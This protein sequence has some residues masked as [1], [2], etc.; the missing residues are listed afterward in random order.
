MSFGQ[1]KHSK[2]VLLSRH[3]LGGAARARARASRA[4]LS[5]AISR[6]TF[7]MPLLTFFRRPA[8][9]VS[10]V[11]KLRHACNARLHS[12]GVPVSVESIESETC[13][14]Y[15]GP[16]PTPSRTYISASL[17]SEVASSSL[18]WIVVVLFGSYMFALLLVTHDCRSGGYPLAAARDFRSGPYL[19][20]F[21]FSCDVIHLCGFSR[22][23]GRHHR[24]WPSLILHVPLF[25]QRDFHLS[26]LRHT[27]LSL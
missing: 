19:N 12:E 25:Y 24:S 6:S 8:A 10:E 26:C 14:Y 23:L 22:A 1:S 4:S 7:C 11:E 16:S 3:Q 20:I 2:L 15:D 13:F 17:S 21:F 9:P 5:S 27:L 18:E